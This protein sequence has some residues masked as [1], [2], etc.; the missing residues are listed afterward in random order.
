MLPQ[1]TDLREQSKSR[2]QTSTAEHHKASS[3]S[4]LKSL[5]HKQKPPPSGLFTYNILSLVDEVEKVY[6]NLIIC[7]I[8][9]TI[10]FRYGNPVMMSLKKL[11]SKV[12]MTMP[13]KV[14]FPGYP[15]LT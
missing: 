13:K 6:N 11:L 10:F 15:N 4:P 14:W 2:Y 9:L 5:Q 8:K 12:M 7:K 3:V 1:Q